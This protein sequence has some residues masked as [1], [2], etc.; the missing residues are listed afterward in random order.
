MSDNTEMQNE[1]ESLI[2]KHGLKGV[3]SAIGNVCFEKAIHLRSN[4]QDSAAAKVW[5]RDGKLIDKIATRVAN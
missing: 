2:D 5:E 4:W 1:L 3:L